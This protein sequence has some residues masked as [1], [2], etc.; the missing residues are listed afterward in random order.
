MYVI[1]IGALTIYYRIIY[2]YFSYFYKFYRKILCF[3]DSTF[4]VCRNNSLL[5]RKIIIMC[6]RT[7]V[8]YKT[9]IVYSD[10]S[11]GKAV[12]VKRPFDT[13]TKHLS[14]DLES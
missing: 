7:N 11:V 3:K 5:L 4:H 13:H 6:L 2:L 1:V 14:N 9:C 10:R 8:T 12:D